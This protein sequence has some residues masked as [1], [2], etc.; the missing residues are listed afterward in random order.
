MESMFKKVVILV[1]GRTKKA[2]ICK[3]YI[4]GEDGATNYCNIKCSTFKGLVRHI[5]KEHS[6]L[7]PDSILCRQHEMIMTT[8]CAVLNHFKMHIEEGTETFNYQD[9]SEE[10]GTCKANINAIKMC[11]PGMSCILI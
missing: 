7:L 4:P 11:R 5:Q 9:E 3:C 1:N 6:I 8:P 2:F 10:C